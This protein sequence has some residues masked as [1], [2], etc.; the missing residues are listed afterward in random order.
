MSFQNFVCWKSSSLPRVLNTE[1]L[2]MDDHFFLATHHPLQMKRA[3]HRSGSP[4]ADAP[5]LAQEQLRDELLDPKRDYVLGAVLGAPGTGKSHLVR[6]L[7]LHLPKEQQRHIVLVRRGATLRRVI[8]LILEDM[9]GRQFDELR[10]RV[11]RASD[12]SASIKATREQFLY[13]LCIAVGPNGPRSKEPLST[14][15]EEE[16]R[17]LLIRGLPVLLRSAV[18]MKELIRDGGIIAELVEHTLGS[19]GMERLGD[20]RKFAVSDIAVNN[21]DISRNSLDAEARSFFDIVRY[22]DELQQQAINWINLNLDWAMTR[23]LDLSGEDLIG[24]MAEVRSALQ[25]QG[26][27]LVLLIEDLSNLQ[28]I[29]SALLEALLVRPKQEKNLCPLR[30][31]FAVTTGYYAGIADNVRERVE[32]PVTLDISEGT[33]VVSAEKLARFASR[34]LNAVRLDES[35]LRRWHSEGATGELPNHCALCPYESTCHPGFGEEHEIGLYPF[36]REALSLMY[37]RARVERESFNPRVLINTVL[38]R[39]LERGAQEIPTSN[40]PPPDL[41]TAMGRASRPMSA[42]QTARIERSVGPSDRKRAVTLVQLWGDESQWPQ[43]ETVIEAFDLKMK[44]RGKDD[45]LPVEVETKVVVSTEADRQTDV[46][47]STSIPRQNETTASSTEPEPLPKE[48]QR[49]LSVIDAWL[50]GGVLEETVTTLLRGFIFNSLSSFIDWDAEMF[51]SSVFVGTSK[52]FQPSSI[53]F[54]NQQTRLSNRPGVVIT[55]PMKGQDRSQLAL[56]LKGL[57][58]HNHFGDWNFT[59]GAGRLRMLGD[60]LEHCAVEVLRQLRIPVGDTVEWSAAPLAAELLAIGAQVNGRPLP[61]Q[62]ADEFEIEVLFSEFR[63]VEARDTSRSSEW[64]KLQNTFFEQGD[65]LREHLRSRALCTKGGYSVGKVLD[66]ATFAPVVRR[67]RSGWTLSTPVAPSSMRPD[68]RYLRD[69]RAQIETGLDLAVEAE[70]RRFEVWLQSVERTIA[71]GEGRKEIQNALEAVLHAAEEQGINAFPLGVKNALEGFGSVRLDQ[72]LS[73]AKALREKQGV[74]R[75]PLVSRTDV[76]AM[77]DKTGGVVVQGE[78]FLDRLE[79]K[80]QGEVAKLS[81]SE[82][83][84]EMQQQI[85]SS[86]SSLCD[87]FRELANPG[88]KN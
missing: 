81:A 87:I 12:K 71:P 70:S 63:K 10:E 48:L 79:G 14:M 22:E 83:V 13:D 80:I 67:V 64:I 44:L 53:Y 19:H 2:Q 58:L 8:E 7:Y 47:G 4:L 55:L 73:V 15:D 86:L 75:L 66:T 52:M 45:P 57:L 38:R 29:D 11:K 72:C 1:A 56:V 46:R 59:D 69:L 9:E 32:L 21:W 61:T 35:E 30:A 60:L 36:T 41:A 43:P 33:T 77:M 26:K 3:D 28:G 6:W 42:E 85:S 34:Y 88:D 82:D 74:G 51:V 50:A 5:L 78:A 40:F 16:D 49:R 31:L 24:L 84:S 18:F 68:A 54:E 17:D 76:V 23:L 65:K 62:T 25:A 39:T 37:D 27:E 20:K